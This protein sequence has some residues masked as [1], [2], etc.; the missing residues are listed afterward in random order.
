MADPSTVSL[1]GKVAV[2]T[3]GSSGIGAAAVRRLAAAGASVAIGYNAGKERAE[4]LIRELAGS[5]HRALRTPMEDTAAL[6]RMADEV[7]SAFGR[8]DV[9]VNSAGFTRLVPHGDLEAL[10]DATIDAIFVANVRGPFAT[11][12]ALAPLMKATG[13]AVVVNVSSIAAFTGAGSNIAYAASKAA[14]DTMSMSLA[15]ALGPEIRVVCV[16]PGIVDT[17]FVPGRSREAVE[18]AAAATPLKK[19]V[20]PDDIAL[21]V[22]ACVTHLKV[23]TGTIIVVDGGRHL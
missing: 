12:R 1:A 18:K 5:G 7:K 23:A 4:A 9:L 15:R 3:G 13:D 6:R 2:V 22:M 14:L 8:C 10:D 16:S 19:I 21:A 17:G 20:G 11:I